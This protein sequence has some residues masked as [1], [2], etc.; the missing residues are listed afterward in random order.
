MYLYDSLLQKTNANFVEIE[1]S[2][3]FCTYL[4]PILSHHMVY[5]R[6]MQR[7]NDQGLHE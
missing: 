7:L 3:S 4:Q 5:R 2:A 6:R 1:R